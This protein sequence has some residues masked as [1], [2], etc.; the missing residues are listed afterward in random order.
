MISPELYITNAVELWASI[1]DLSEPVPGLIRAEAP[2]VTRAFTV[3]PTTAEVLLD[4]LN[5]EPLGKPIV[6]EDSFGAP[7]G[8]VPENVTLKHMPVMVRQPGPVEVTGAVQR[9]TTLDGYETARQIII[10]G[11][12]ARAGFPPSIL[13]DPQWAVWQASNEGI[14]AA[15]MYAFDDGQ[16]AGIYLLATLPEHRGRGLARALLTHAIAATATRYTVLVATLDG[17]PL[18]EKLGFQTV[19]NAIWYFRSGT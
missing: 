15:A 6:L 10:D 11:F 2:H 4:F 14:P 9:I 7:V 1:A 17:Q 18:Y 3:K 19:S 8:D 5:Q 13:D 12:P 16:A